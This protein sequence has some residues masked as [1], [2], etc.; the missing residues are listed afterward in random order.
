MLG[1]SHI[2]VAWLAPGSGIMQT[3]GRSHAGSSL[4]VPVTHV[5]DLALGSW[6]LVL[7]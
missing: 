5:G 2:G 6:L 3:F 7:A 1:V 4:W